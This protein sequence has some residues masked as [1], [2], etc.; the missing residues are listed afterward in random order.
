MSKN[1]NG[2]HLSGVGATYIRVSTDHQDTERQRAAVQA[3]EQTHR[4]TIAKQHWF[5]DEGWARDE[6]DKRPDFQ[7]LMKLAESGCVQWIIVDALDR[8]GTKDSHQLVHYLYRLRECSCKLYDGTGKEWTSADIAT[9]ITAV[10]EGE[11]SKGEQTSKSH[12]VLGGK[13]EKARLGEWQG[14]PVRLGFDV[15]C[16]GRETDKELWRVVFESRG[17]RLKVYPDGRTERFDGPENFP[18]SQPMTEVLRIAP[19]RDKAKIDAAIS[20]FKRFATESISFT[21][22]AHDLSKLGWRNGG[23]GYFQGQQVE[24]MLGDPIYLGYYAWNKWHFGKFHRYQ[25]GQTV[26]ELNYG[27]RG[28]KNDKADWVQSRRLFK[29]LVDQKTW[30]TV[31]QKLTERPKRANAPRS[32]AQYLAGLV[33]CGNCGC[34]MVTGSTRRENPRRDGFKGE[35]HEYFCSTYFAA[36]REKRRHECKCLRNGVFQDTLEDYVEQY[37]KETG[38]RMELL[39]DGLDADALTKPMQD[40]L[41][42]QH[43]EY[44]DAMMRMLDYIRDNDP[45][46]WEE[47]WQPV[48]DDHEVPVERAVEYYRRCFS[49]DRFDEQLGRLEAEHSALTKSCLN[50]KTERS[51]AKVN[52]QLAELESKIKHLEQQKQNVG[53]TVERQWRE[54]L[55]LSEAIQKAERSMTG[56]GN[57]RRRAEALRSVIQRIECTFTST[58]ETGGGWGKKNSRLATVTIYPVVGDPAAFSASSKGTLM[59]SSAH[60]FMKRTRVGRMRYTIRAGLSRLPRYCR[61]SGLASQ[62]SCKRGSSVTISALPVMRT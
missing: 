46:A 40:R 54:V 48:S 21:A 1:G 61:K 24:E 55:E 51:I 13:A 22:L 3:F 42:A 7:R 35:R 2:L 17:K 39:T 59:Y 14:G 25:N 58:G 50:L 57:L 52:D 56:D 23:G 38:R 28:S 5:K 9:I 34:R 16:Y 8:F 60:S 44:R 18:K 11:K 6:A 30:N 45:A 36:V 4:V 43:D 12:R 10:V 33:Y 19:S 62:I 32:A 29:P 53:D 47:M 31:Q 26:P 37:L 27:E 15:A 41:I 49:A 20:V